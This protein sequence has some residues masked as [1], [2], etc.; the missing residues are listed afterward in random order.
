MSNPKICILAHLMT[1]LEPITPALESPLSHP[2]LKQKAVA[3][4]LLNEV[5]QANTAISGMLLTNMEKNC[6]F[7]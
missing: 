1:P 4:E 5:K 7:T 2:L 3:T 6:K